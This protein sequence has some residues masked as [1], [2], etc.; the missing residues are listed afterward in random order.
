M[1][2]ALEDAL[3]FFLDLSP[4]TAC[5]P[6]DQLLGGLIYPVR[7][8]VRL[9]EVEQLLE[10]AELA[11][12]AHVRK[13]DGPPLAGELECLLKLHILL[14]HQIGYDAACASRDAGVAVNQ[15]SSFGYA[16]LDEGDGGR[17]VPDQAG[18][19]RI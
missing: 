13:D 12:E 19:A 2:E 18:L 9:L 1:G 6:L 15:D 5:G 17:E 10:L 8:R 14:L 4:L 3:V 16:L 11:L 7:A